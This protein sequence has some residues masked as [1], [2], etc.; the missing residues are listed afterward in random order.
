MEIAAAVKMAI[1]DLATACHASPALIDASAQADASNIMSDAAC[2]VDMQHGISFNAAISSIG[3]PCELAAQSCEKT[4]KGSGLKDL[5]S[6]GAQASPVPIDS[7]SHSEVQRPQHN[8]VSFN[9]AT[10][11]L[12]AQGSDDTQNVISF[13]AAITGSGCGVGHGH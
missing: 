4:I 11:E 7:L 13:N 10:P 5:N 12:A 6:Q 8:M 1:L 3:G 9:A 2:E